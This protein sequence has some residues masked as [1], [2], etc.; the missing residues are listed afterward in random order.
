[1]ETRDIYYHDKKTANPCLD[2]WVAK[3]S[4][5]AFGHPRTWCLSAVIP[6]Y[7]MGAVYG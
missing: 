1:M 3:G 6:T 7:D 5:P 4:T 2:G